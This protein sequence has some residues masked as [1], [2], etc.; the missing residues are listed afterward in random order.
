VW[1]AGAPQQTL[2][3][4]SSSPLVLSPSHSPTLPHV[5]CRNGYHCNIDESILRKLAQVLVSTGLRDLGYDYVNIDGEEG[6]RAS[7]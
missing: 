6:D 1:C 4:Q 7:L 3:S 5:L 2:G